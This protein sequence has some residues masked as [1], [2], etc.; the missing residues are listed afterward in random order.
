ML[1]NRLRQQMEKALPKIQYVITKDGINRLMA[2]LKMTVIQALEKRENV[3]IRKLDLSNAFNTVSRASVT[4]ALYDKRETL[5]PLLT[6]W[7]AYLAPPALGI[8]E[9]EHCSELLQRQTNVKSSHGILVPITQGVSQGDVFASFLF[10]LTIQ[11]DL[12]KAEQQYGVKILAFADDIT[13]VGD[14]AKVEAATEYLATSLKQHKLEMNTSKTEEWDPYDDPSGGLEMLGSVL[15]LSPWKRMDTVQRHLENLQEE[16]NK[17]IAMVTT[18]DLQIGLSYLRYRWNGRLNHLFRT[19]GEYDHQVALILNEFQNRVFPTILA[20]LSNHNVDTPFEYER[21][22]EQ[23]RLPI[24]L[25]GLGFDDLVDQYRAAVLAGQIEAMPHM[26]SE[27]ATRGSI[28]ETILDSNTAKSHFEECQKAVTDHLDSSLP[29]GPK[30]TRARESLLERLD[31]GTA[32]ALP[33]GLSHLAQGIELSYLKTR[34]PFAPIQ[35]V[36]REAY[37]AAGLTGTGHKLGFQTPNPTNFQKIQASLNEWLKLARFNVFYKRWCVPPERSDSSP[38]LKKII[39]RYKHHF[40]KMAAP[41]VFTRWFNEVP[42]ITNVDDVMV[43]NSDTFAMIIRLRMFLPLSF[44]LANHEV[45][46]FC[47]KTDLEPDHIYCCQSTHGFR[48]SLHNGV[49]DL[50]F[51]H[52]A[53]AIARETRIRVGNKRGRDD[54][55]SVDESVTT[56]ERS[57]VLFRVGDKRVHLDVSAVA[58]GSNETLAKR[59][60]AKQTKWDG[61]DNKAPNAVGEMFVFSTVGSIGPKSWQWVKRFGRQDQKIQRGDIF[62]RIHHIVAQHVQ[63]I[64]ATAETC[65]SRMVANQSDIVRHQRGCKVILLD[66][67]YDAG[68]PIGKLTTAAATTRRPTSN[69]SYRSSREK[70]AHSNRA[71]VRGPY[72]CKP[73]TNLHF[74]QS[75]RNE[76]NTSTRGGSVAWSKL[77]EGLQFQYDAPEDYSSETSQQDVPQDVS[78]NNQKQRTDTST[79]TEPSRNLIRQSPVAAAAAANKSQQR[80]QT[81]ASQIMKTDRTSSRISPELLSSQLD[82][83]GKQQPRVLRQSSLASEED[84]AKARSHSHSQQRAHV[85]TSQI[86]QKNGT[87]ASASP[88]QLLQEDGESTVEQLCRANQVLAQQGIKV[89]T[90]DRG[91]SFTNWSAAWSENRG[92]SAIEQSM[93]EVSSQAG[94]QRT[95]EDFP[96]T[97]M[98]YPAATDR[99]TRTGR[100]EDNTTAYDLHCLDNMDRNG[101]P[102]SFSDCSLHELPNNLLHTPVYSDQSSEGELSEHAGLDDSESESKSSE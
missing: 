24:C 86:Y 5:A 9:K 31:N 48:I 44:V 90:P 8:L 22:C 1:A 64:V 102:V 69:A 78:R 25:G 7:L 82:Q 99:D 63:I 2:T 33:P 36:T 47:Q 23:A 68:M 72:S 6:Y 70:W 58:S 81:A 101:L 46:P 83:Q 28:P 74:D 85:V 73:M 49:R 95:V 80:M 50:L 100:S 79:P 21:A 43:D 13:I 32:I 19:V 39:T 42:N 66:V 57:D 27:M 30:E 15:T 88:E 34:L 53:S 76:D 52:L 75:D 26:I 89:S 55:L 61:I 84:P 14:H 38:E 77:E 20:C 51:Y 92:D 54:G 17:L 60:Q 97:Q 67:P 41:H 35:D 45:C 3:L 98:E 87:G 71:G 18:T 16:I 56:Q 11:K 91:A 4:K 93:T 59:E 65:W 37:K 12:E 62:N 29:T 40:D 10:A 96:L 94:T